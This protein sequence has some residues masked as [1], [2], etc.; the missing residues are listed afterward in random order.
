MSKN[1][2]KKIDLAVGFISFLSLIAF[3]IVSNK[4]ENSII[5]G[6]LFALTTFSFVVTIKTFLK[7]IKEPD[8]FVEKEKISEMFKMYLKNKGFSIIYDVINVLFYI[9]IFFVMEYGY[10]CIPFILYS[11]TTLMTKIIEDYEKSARTV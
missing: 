10:L 6:I 4:Q 1:T 2:F 8:F 5:L 7:E 9:I 3:L 11:I